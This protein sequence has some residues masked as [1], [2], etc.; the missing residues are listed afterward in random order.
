MTAMTV[1]IVDQALTR[2]LGIINRATINIYHVWSSMYEICHKSMIYASLGTPLLK[3][4]YLIQTLVFRQKKERPLSKL[5]I[6][7]FEVV[8]SYVTGGL[9]KQFTKKVTRNFFR[10][11]GNRLNVLWNFTQNFTIYNIHVFLQQVVTF[12]C[13]ILS[14]RL[15][16]SRHFSVSTWWVRTLMGLS[17]VLL[18]G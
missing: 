13:H 1:R 2:P 6:G 17:K 15:M 5:K 3:F 11:L 9:K 16:L 10:I 14:I 18:G 7:N 8:R 4:S 12:D